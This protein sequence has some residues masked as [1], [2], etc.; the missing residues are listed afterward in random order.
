MSLAEIVARGH[1]TAQPC[2]RVEQLLYLA[3]YKRRQAA[4]G[5]KITAR[6]SAATAAIPITNG[7][8]E[9][10]AY[11]DR[12]SPRSSGRASNDHCATRPPRP[13][14]CIGQCPPGAAQL[15]LRPASWRHAS[16]C[17][18]TIPTPS[19][20]PKNSPT[21]SSEDL[22]WLGIDRVAQGPAVRPDRALR[23]GGGTADSE[24]PALSVLRDREELDRKRK[25]PARPRQAADLR[26]R[27]AE[28]HRRRKRAVRSRGPQA[29]LAL[30]AR[31]RDGAVGRSH[32]GRAAVDTASMSDPVLVREDGT[33]LYTL[34]IVVDDIDLGITHVIR[35]EDHV[36][37]TGAQIEIFEALGADAAC[38]RPP[39]SADR[40]RRA[41]AVE[42]RAV[43]L[44]FGPARGGDRT[45][46][47]CVLRRD[48]RHVRPGRAACEPR[49]A[50]RGFRLRQAIARAGPV[51]STRASAAQC[52]APAC[53]ALR[54]GGRAA[55]RARR[56]RWAG[57]LG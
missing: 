31:A 17:A 25:R 49:R 55:S 43:E 14:V 7:F 1:A 54:R 50:R 2:K 42:A 34:P 19:A 46:R 13:G 51:R 40:A 24:R 35:G 9:S 20:R 10:G 5:V 6:R 11:P 53:A 28:A 26:S 45:D 36:S 33:Y 21:A 37:N 15:A 48:H 4:P 8:R 44:D 32:R 18:S 39:Q 29:A 47:G 38:L 57:V 52:A 3:E 12:A 23:C 27:R 22:A 56:E 16:C 30:Q 41:G